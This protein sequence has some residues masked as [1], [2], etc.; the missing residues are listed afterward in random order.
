MFIKVI[1][2]LLSGFVLCNILLFLYN[3]LCII[4]VFNIKID[5]AMKNIEILQE[6]EIEL[7]TKVSKKINEKSDEKIL[8]NLPKT[9]NKELNTFELQKE[10]ALFNKEIN[11]I[12]I[13]GSIK[14]SDEEKSLISLLRNNSIEL[15][16][17]E[18]YYNEEAEKYNK[19]IKKIKYLFVRIIK[20]LRKKEIFNF[21][22]TVDFEILKE[23]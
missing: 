20:R 19:T 18:Q 15:E 11:D 21:E 5:E 6:K 8:K 7:L 12:I 4:K 22:K 2:V 1:I 16:A 9:K 10:L 13:E 3:K 14:L 17:I 23:K